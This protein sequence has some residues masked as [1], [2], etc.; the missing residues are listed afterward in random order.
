M[1]EK[2]VFNF[3]KTNI[4]KSAALI[5][6]FIIS[7]S[8]VFTFS[9][10]AEGKDHVVRVGWFESPFNQTDEYGRRS[11]YAYEYEQKIAAFTGWTYEYIRGSWP[12]LLEMLGEGKIDILADVSYTEQRQSKMLFS[13]LPMGAEEY[14]LYIDPDNSEISPENLS[15]LN[16][17]KIG[18]DKGSVQIDC[19]KEW[20]ESNRINAEVIEM[21]DS[22]EDS[23][24]L[25]YRGSIDLYLTVGG[26][27][28]S[29][30]AFPVCKV[31]ESQF[32]FA[33]SKERPELLDELNTAMNW[34]QTKDP[35]YNQKLNIKYLN[36][37]GISHVLNSAEK[38]WI[39]EH[40]PV[41][42]G[43]Q[44]NYLAFC[45]KDPKTGELTGALKDYLECAADCLDNAHIDF[46]AVAYP[47]A[48]AA[49][50]ALENGEVDCMFPANLTD[51]DGEKQGYF[52][53][54]PLMRTDISAIILESEKENF[55]GKEHVTVAVN[56]GNP[57]YDMF[58][59]DNFPDWQSVI[60]KD[61]PECLKAISEGKADCLLMSYFRYNNIASLCKKYGLTSVSTGVEMDYSFAVRRDSNVLYSIFDKI[62]DVVPDSTINA[63]LSYYFT[64]DSKQTFAELLFDNIWAVIAVS[65]LVILLII[66]LLLIITFTRGKERQNVRNLLQRRNSTRLPVC[67]TKTSFMN[68]RIVCS[69]NIPTNRWMQ[70]F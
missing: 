70:L 40:G 4:L 60:F 21:T 19:F 28:D 41:R 49:M 5:L 12:D 10:S 47:T 20:A 16:G 6:S 13:S 18:A 65:T 25:L 62:N 36:A 64:E 1:K 38:N 66:A 22:L 46:E 7:L 51:Y 50:A 67:T 8:F 58:L 29:D 52:M 48:S 11:G 27:F 45:A 15:L 34:I 57:N 37:S 68:M 54:A 32:Y 44:D 56:A 63:A 53:T 39:S 33:V 55:S 24:D 42:V 30:V 17:K 2:R 69:I 9:V 31:G 14:Y 26:Y 3:L 43:Y 61:T 35:F 59:V 23:I